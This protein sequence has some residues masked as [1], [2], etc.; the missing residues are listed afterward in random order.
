MV[1]VVEVEDITANGDIEVC[2]SVFY[3]NFA[4]LLGGF[5][6]SSVYAVVVV[7]GI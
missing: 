4:P 7:L 3:F 2:L 5:F 1:V 6:S